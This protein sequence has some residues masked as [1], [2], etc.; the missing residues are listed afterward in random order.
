MIRAY[1]NEDLTA[2]AALYCAAFAAAPWNE[3]WPQETAA[4][5]IADLMCSLLSVGLL[6]EEDGVIAGMLLG[7][8]VTY[9]YGRE[10]LI[11]ELCVLPDRQRGGIGSKLLEY[12]VKR[13]R[14]KGYAGIFLNTT[15]R[16]PSEAFYV[17]NGFE[18]QP[19]TVAMYR[20]LK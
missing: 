11:H 16:Y 13:L 9:L 14:T 19:R 17:K 10:L 7:S 12:V 8:H 20:T 15:R 6:Y 3:H 18:L 4:Q 1:R 2:C 5:R